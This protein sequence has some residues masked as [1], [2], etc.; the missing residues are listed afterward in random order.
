[1]NFKKN[2]C[3]INKELTT[4]FDQVWFGLDEKQKQLFIMNFK[5]NDDE[6]F[7]LINFYCDMALSCRKCPGTLINLFLC[8]LIDM[9]LKKQINDVCCVRRTWHNVMR[10][11]GVP[12]QKK[13]LNKIFFDSNNDKQC[14][15]QK[16]F[17]IGTEYY[18]IN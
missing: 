12:A 10:C 16:I 7:I 9:K 14:N 8:R 18:S 17:F 4:F 5:K 3:N 2:V 11:V 13:A 1:M 6:L 15:Q